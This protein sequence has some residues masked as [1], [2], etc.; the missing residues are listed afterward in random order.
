M[1]KSLTFLITL[2]LIVSINPV[3]ASAKTVNA[4]ISPNSFFYFFDIAL[5]EI[6]L[7]FT[8]NTEKKVKI[9]LEYA[10]E[11]IAELAEISKDKTPEVYI[12]T[13]NKYQKKISYAKEISAEIEQSEKKENILTL[14]SEKEESNSDIIPFVITGEDVEM[15]EILESDKASSIIKDK[16][17]TRPLTKF[18]KMGAQGNEVCVLQKILSMESVLDSKATCY[19]GSKTYWAVSKLVGKYGYFQTS[20][21][22]GTIDKTAIN[23][24]NKLYMIDKNGSIQKNLSTDIK[25]VESTSSFRVL[26]PTQKQVDVSTQDV[27]EKET[28]NDDTEDYEKRF[29]E[30]FDKATLNPRDKIKLDNII[31]QMITNKESNANIRFVID[32]FFKKYSVNKL[33]FADKIKPA[34]NQKNSNLLNQAK[35]ELEAVYIAVETNKR[36]LVKDELYFLNNRINDLESTISYIKDC[37]VSNASLLA[38]INSRYGRYIRETKE[39]GQKSIDAV[40][41]YP[42]NGESVRLRELDLEEKIKE[43]EKDREIAI[44][45]IKINCS[46]FLKNSLKRTLSTLRKNI[47]E[48]SDYANSYENLQKSIVI[49]LGKIEA[50]LKNIKNGKDVNSTSVYNNYSSKVAEIIYEFNSINSGV[51]SKVSQAKYD[52]SK[53]TRSAF[54][55]D[56][57]MRDARSSFDSIYDEAEANYKKWKAANT[58]VKCWS[59][60]NYSGGLINGKSETSIRCETGATNPVR[61]WSTTEYKGGINGTSQTSMRCE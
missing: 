61:C 31:D 26:K 46:D 4:G 21:N 38:D 28:E 17:E 32:D 24:I 51:K 13:V 29:Q 19:Y 44:N 41:Y 34:I 6:N 37:S 48:I 57:K 2:L 22:F 16:I 11:R 54:K 58:P 53:S 36:N 59:D 10:D 25:T 49:E 40:K 1:K 18:M 30:L 7:F 60:T 35:N 52:Y 8:F 33:S 5:E 3:F 42:D 55:N 39:R 20:N 45:S 47:S 50:A 23:L 9:A 56:A 14:I 27:Q 15:P 43:H 12:E